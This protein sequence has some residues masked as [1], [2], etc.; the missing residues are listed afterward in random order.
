VATLD[1]VPE[2]AAAACALG[3]RYVYYGAANAAWQVRS[4]PPIEVMRQSPAL[5]T[6]FEQGKATVFR[7]TLSC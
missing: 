3:A 6:V 7:I 4:F 5:E 1:Q 2:A